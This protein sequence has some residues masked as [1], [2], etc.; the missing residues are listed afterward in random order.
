M[1][2]ES[3]FAMFLLLQDNEEINMEMVKESFRRS[4]QDTITLEA[5]RGILKKEVSERNSFF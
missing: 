3:G 5:T 2:C 4:L 1:N